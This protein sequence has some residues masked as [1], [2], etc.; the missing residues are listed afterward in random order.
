[1]PNNHKRSPS[2]TILLGKRFVVV[3]GQLTEHQPA[4]AKFVCKLN[5]EQLFSR[6]L[7][8]FAGK[9]TLP[10]IEKQHFNPVCSLNNFML[11][12]CSL[13]LTAVSGIIAA[14]R[15][16]PQAKGQCQRYSIHIEIII[17]VIRRTTNNNAKKEAV[18]HSNSFHRIRHIA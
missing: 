1:M 11:P 3:N 12:T 2:Y 13:V 15:E 5:I 7:Y 16:K 4:I 14:T 9:T 10:T 8:C 6:P 17:Y 18:S